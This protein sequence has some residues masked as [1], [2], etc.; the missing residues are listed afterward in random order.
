MRI[1]KM[2]KLVKSRRQ[3]KQIFYSLA[4][5]HVVKLLRAALEHVKEESR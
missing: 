4:D 1:L 3:G 2:T 5:Q